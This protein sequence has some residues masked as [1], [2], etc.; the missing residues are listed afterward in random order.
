[1][2][3]NPTWRGSLCPL[4]LCLLFLRLLSLCLLSLCLLFTCPVQAQTTT[5][6]RRQAAVYFSDGVVL[7]GEVLLTP[8]INF[9]LGGITGPEQK[10]AQTRTFNV[11]IVREMSFA[12]FTRSQMEPER[13][14][15]PYKWDDKDRPYAFRPASPTRCAN[16]PAPSSSPAAR[17]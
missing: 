15:V 17:R 5:A 11:D 1:M 13:M 6:P 12:P 10:H 8:G 14:T 2:P 16:W 7:Q 9:S 4:S 3:A